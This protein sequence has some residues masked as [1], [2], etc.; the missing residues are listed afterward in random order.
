MLKTS[1]VIDPSAIEPDLRSTYP[2]HLRGAVHGRR[3]RRLGALT[4][5]RHLS[6]VHVELPPG[7]ASSL[8]VWQS[9][10]DEFVLVLQGEATLVTDEGEEVIRAGQSAGFPAGRSVGHQIVNRGDRPVV[11]VEVASI[12]DDNIS[13]YPDHDLVQVPDGRGRR[14]VR[15]DGSPY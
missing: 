2:E 4:G 14:F 3:K 8:K 10:E 5:L 9:H 6:V 7:A 1:A 12:A 15:R 11:F 13:T